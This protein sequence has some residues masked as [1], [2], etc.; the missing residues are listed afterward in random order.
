MDIL[1]FL[2]GGGIRF[3]EQPEGSTAVGLQA[4]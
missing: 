4:H 1:Y 3:G 2:P